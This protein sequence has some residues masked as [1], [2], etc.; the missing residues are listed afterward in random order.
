MPRVAHL[1][2][3]AVAVTFVPAVAFPQDG[4]GAPPPFAISPNGRFLATPGAAG[5][6][7]LWESSSGTLYATLGGHRDPEL[8][9]RTRHAEAELVSA[10]GLEGLSRRATRDSAA[11]D[12]LSYVS[13]V[14]AL[15]FSGNGK[16]AAG[17]HHGFVRIW[18]IESRTLEVEFLVGEPLTALDQRSDRLDRAQPVV[19]LAFSPD[20]RMVVVGGFAAA[21]TSRV[22]LAAVESG[23]VVRS[24][25]G[26]AAYDL[27][28]DRRRLGIAM[29]GSRDVALWDVASGAHVRTITEDQATYELQPLWWVRLS[30][31]GDLVAVGISARTRGDSGAVTVWDVQSGKRLWRQAPLP[32]G[33]PSRPGARFSPDGQTIITYFNTPEIREGFLGTSST[34]PKAPAL[35]AAR[36][37]AVIAKVGVFEGGMDGRVTSMEPFV[38]SPDGRFVATMIGADAR[39]ML[40][41]RWSVELRLWESPRGVLR[42]RMA[43][44]D[45]VAF[46]PDS[47]ALLTWTR[48][49]ALR[50]WD[51]A[52]MRQV[53]TIRDYGRSAN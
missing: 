16:V 45:P 53:W 14:R 46:A 37:G 12:A 41:R 51:L 32:T 48:D 26:V 2:I 3:G 39:R 1:L 25:S 40:A 5:A 27:S 34:M 31:A 22:A 36:T 23:S 30:P 4:A 8:L 52:T 13:E 33:F 35:R 7:N 29:K 50:L 20:D 21:G 43:N 49:G 17:G 24:F 47:G 15:A 28:F 38:F 19:S 6:V 44:E 11:D 42:H 18:D 9:R 10:G